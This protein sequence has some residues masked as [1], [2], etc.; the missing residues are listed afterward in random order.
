M[1]DILKNACPRFEFILF[2]TKVN[3]GPCTQGNM[4][5]HN[6]SNFPAENI[7]KKF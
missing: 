1:K 6:L 5:L 7:F 3:F 2:K 4:S